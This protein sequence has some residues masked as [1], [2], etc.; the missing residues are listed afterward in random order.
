MKCT[1]SVALFAVA[2]IASSVLVSCKKKPQ[3]VTPLPGARAG[4][5]GGE[6]PRGPI[7]PSEGTQPIIPEPIKP[8]PI[9]IPPE[10]VPLTAEIGQWVPAAEQPFRTDTVYFDFDKSNIKPSE[11]PKLDKVAV[12]MKSTYT[13]KG[14]RIEGH[15]DERGTEEYNRALGERRALAIREYLIRSGIEARLIDTISFGEDR[16]AEPGHNEAAWSKNRRGE[17]IL[18]VPPGT[19]P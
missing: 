4:T 1:K 16:P 15:C 17:F 11:T 3:N 2:L 7:V 14:L 9:K 8:E 19:N 13:G 18:L 6:A 10:G 12:E 5:P